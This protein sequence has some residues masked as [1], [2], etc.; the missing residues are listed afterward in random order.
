MLDE[1]RQISSLISLPGPLS[2]GCR[3]CLAERDI[4]TCDNIPDMRR[5]LRLSSPLLSSLRTSSLGAGRVVE[6]GEEGERRPDRKTLLLPHL[7][8]RPGRGLPL[9]GGVDEGRHEVRGRQ[10]GGQAGDGE[11]EGG[12]REDERRSLTWE[13][14]RCRLDSGA[15]RLERMELELLELELEL[16]LA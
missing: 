6:A 12:V 15:G 2:A 13:K 3:W 11:L 16:E 5:S 9:Q 7:G 8:L 14:G 4:R 10:E 1:E